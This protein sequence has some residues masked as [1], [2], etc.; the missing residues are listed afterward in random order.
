WCQNSR[1]SWL[2]EGDKN[3]K[4]FHS[5]AS[6]RR[7]R[8]FIRGIKDVSGIW[9]ENEKNIHRVTDLVDGRA[10]T[11]MNETLMATFTIVEIELA[12]CQMHPSKALG[13][14]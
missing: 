5:K 10:T 7:T 4:F 13:S 12:W 14:D 9:R 1:V 3:T 2:R 11:D 8:N 6:Q